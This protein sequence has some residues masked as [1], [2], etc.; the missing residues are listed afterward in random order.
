MSQT[1]VGAR[2]RTTVLADIRALVQPHTRLVW[3]VTADDI[4]VVRP[5]KKADPRPAKLRRA[6]RT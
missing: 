6:P 3:S 4:I 2:G 1:V 5:E